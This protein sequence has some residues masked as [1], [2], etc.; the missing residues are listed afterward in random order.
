MKLCQWALPK[1]TGPASVFCPTTLPTPTLHWI[2]IKHKAD[3]SAK[4]LSTC[5]ALHH[6]SVP[7]SAVQCFLVKCRVVQSCV[8]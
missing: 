2:E 8:V 6:S 4:C 3:I 1:K 7:F 5:G